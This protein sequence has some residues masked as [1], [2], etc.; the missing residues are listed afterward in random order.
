MGKY[1]LKIVLMD[2][3]TEV[4]YAYEGMAGLKK[5]EKRG[6]ASF[7]VKTYDFDTAAEREAYLKGIED[8]KYC[9]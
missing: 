7:E 9:S 8:M 6:D 4:I 5:A 2:D 1:R 3:N